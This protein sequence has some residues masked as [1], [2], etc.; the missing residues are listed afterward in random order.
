MIKELLRWWREVRGP[1]RLAIG[2][3][4]LLFCSQFFPYMR[5]SS[6]GLSTH[7]LDFVIQIALHEL[8]QKTITGWE[9]HSWAPLTL[10]FLAAFYGSTLCESR[11]WL[12]FGYWLTLI[13]FV[14]AMAGS[15]RP[16]LQ[17]ASM[18][19]VSLGMVF[20]AALW[21]WLSHPP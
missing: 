4:V 15:M 17:G 16:N 14:V 21:N 7:D 8:G 9:L 11:H 10:M 2:A 18:G 5:Q 12:R 13:L 20:V 19:L 1:R 3:I 6:A